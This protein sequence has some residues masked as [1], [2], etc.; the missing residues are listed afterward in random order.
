MNDKELKFLV[1]MAKDIGMTATTFDEIYKV[2]GGYYCEILNVL[3]DCKNTC[4]C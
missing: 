4:C 1:E 2:C 3:N